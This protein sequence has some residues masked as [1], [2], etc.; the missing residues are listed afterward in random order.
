VVERKG[1]QSDRVIVFSIIVLCVVGEPTFKAIEEYRIDRYFREVVGIL[2][3]PS[4]W[5]LLQ[6]IEQLSKV[7][8][9]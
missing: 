4:A 8:G 9:G 3:I 6:R 7:C 2:Q 1:V 5:T